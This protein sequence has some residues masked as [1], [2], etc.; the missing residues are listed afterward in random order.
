M[1]K[2]ISFALLLVLLTLFSSCDYEKIYAEGEVTSVYH[3]N[4]KGYDGL[5]ISDAFQ[6]YV[7][8]SESEEEIRISANNN[9][10][11]K[12]VVQ[13]DGDE[14]I[15]RLKNHT[16]VRGN[17]VMNAYI[18]TK[19]L[20]RFSID[21]ASKL[22]LENQ[23]K[24]QD[25]KIAVSGASDFNGELVA[26]RLKMELE[27]ASTIDV[28]GSISSLDAELSGSSD[29]LD[30]GLDISNLDINLAGASTAFLSVDENI[31]VKASGASTLHYKGNATIQASELSG[32][33]QIIK[34]N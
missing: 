22:I 29:L 24:V 21:G 6:V 23:W 25:G 20:S 8:F 2:Q 17:A 32:S 34:K 10:H 28:I 12:I 15:I 30:Y 1:K 19:N 11:E 33:S 4:I 5:R 31:S 3:N 18:T 7:Y 26:D 16:S 9:L 27:G 13:K 14:L